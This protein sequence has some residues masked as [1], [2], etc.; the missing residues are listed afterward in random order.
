MPVG[1]AGGTI[2]TIPAN[3]LLVK[4]IAVTGLNLGYYMGWSPHD[5][6][7]EEEPKIRPMMEKIGAWYGAGLIKPRVAG[8]FP[9]DSFRDAMGMVLGR[10]AIGRV[11]IVF[12]EEAERHGI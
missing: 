4:N 3:L 2:Q 6:R 12:D 8:V 11:A 9:L 5:A 1:F 7:Y 10:K